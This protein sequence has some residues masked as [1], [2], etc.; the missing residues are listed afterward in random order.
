MAAAA[1]AAVAA[2][3]CR[4]VRP[5]VS[6]QSVQLALHL[7]P[8]I[9]SCLA[10]AAQAAEVGDIDTFKRVASDARVV[11]G[12]MEAHGLR[13]ALGH[14]LLAERAQP[15][16]RWLKLLRVAEKEAAAC[17]DVT[18]DDSFGS[19]RRGGAKGG[20]GGGGERPPA[21]TGQ[22]QRRGQPAVSEVLNY[23][24]ALQYG[25]DTALLQKMPTSLWVFDGHRTGCATPLRWATET[26]RREAHSLGILGSL[27]RWRCRLHSLRHAFRQPARARAARRDLALDRLRREAQRHI[28]EG[29]A[30]ATAEAA[31]VAEA[32]AAAE[33]SPSAAMAALAP[34]KHD[35]RGGYS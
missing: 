16:A 35:G 13:K 7:G 18:H 6:E 27:V 4:C 29:T 2:R 14:L 19:A 33:A 10:E 24:E 12:F 21:R 9:R 32:A 8:R 25:G 30:A 22:R 3:S 20:G 17:L 28:G 11:A 15:P 34:G 1:V 26:I 31:A 5:R 23:E